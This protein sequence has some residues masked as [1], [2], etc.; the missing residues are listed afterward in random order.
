MSASYSDTLL[1]NSINIITEDSIMQGLTYTFSPA[2]LL[3]FFEK[4]GL[5][6]TVM[7]TILSYGFHDFTVE[8]YNNLFLPV[9]NK[10][11]ADNKK[12]E[13]RGLVI[14]GMDFKWGKIA[15]AFFKAIIVMY[16]VYI[17]ALGIKQMIKSA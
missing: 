2:K 8:L 1:S 13:D 14:K 10:E 5:I 11:N 3:Y 7:M 16:I 9:L 15:I 6:S 17:I 12:L 4:S